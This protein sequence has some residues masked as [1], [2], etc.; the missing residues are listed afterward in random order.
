MCGSNPTIVIK[1]LEWIRGF[2]VSLSLIFKPSQLPTVASWDRQIHWSLS[3]ALHC[4]IVFF[5]VVVYRYV[6]L[7]FF[8]VISEGFF[9]FIYW[10]LTLSEFDWVWFLAEFEWI[11]L[12]FDSFLEESDSN[13]CAFRFNLV[14]FASIWF[15]FY[16]KH[17]DWLLES[18]SDFCI[19]E[20]ELG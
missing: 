12:N 13:L 15:C 3:I 16:E 9:F 10:L 4:L 19:W 11:W 1:W 20:R 7:W 17:F 8:F 5:F 14:C 18:V 6:I 2:A